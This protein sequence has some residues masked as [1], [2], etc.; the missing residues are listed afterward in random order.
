MGVIVYSDIRV[1]VNKKPYLIHN[2]PA[3]YGPI[4]SYF[5]DKDSAGLLYTPLEN[6]RSSGR[7]TI[8]A[9]IDMY[10]NKVDFTFDSHDQ[11]REIEKYLGTYIAVMEQEEHYANRE[12]LEYLNRA[13]LLFKFL[14][15]KVENL[16]KKQ[17]KN[18]VNKNP[19]LNAVTNFRN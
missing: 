13:R 1:L 8:S 18:K 4:E 16:D 11:L 12:Q 19:F 15:S 7:Y 6:E 10:F 14:H 9:L 3:T 2:V 17:Y 5:L